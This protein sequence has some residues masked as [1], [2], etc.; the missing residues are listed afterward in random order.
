MVSGTRPLNIAISCAVTSGSMSSTNI[1]LS[2]LGPI[3]ARVK[4]IDASSL[5]IHPGL[6]IVDDLGFDSL[7]ITELLYS[8]EEN[9]L[10]EIPY[11]RLRAE[12]LR[13]LGALHNF[14]VTE[15]KPLNA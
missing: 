6:D 11:E 7:D 3:V 13:N 5:H 9:L 14:L 8:I 12:H 1:T 10:V 2:K 15:A 4:G